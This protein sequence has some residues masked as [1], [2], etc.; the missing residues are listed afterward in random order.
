MFEALLLTA[1]LAADLDP[2]AMLKTADA[3]RQAFL[4]SSLRLRATIE[5]ADKP[6]Q[7]GEFDIHIGNDDQQ[8]VVFRDK[9][10][11][12][13]KFLIVGDRAWLLVPGARNPVA[14]TPNQRMM[15]AMAFTDIARVRLSSDYIGTLRPGMEPCGEPAQP[16]RVMDI[17]ATIKTAPYAS[18]ALW[19]DGDGLLRKAVYALASGKP[20]KEISYRYRDNLGQLEPSGMTLVDLLMPGSNAT[21]ML[22]IVSRRSV[23]HP[24]AMF[25]PQEQVKR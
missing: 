23:Q 21:T 16:C 1:A 13:R 10:Q 3:P 24:A 9:R 11:K 6:S 20:A 18:G 15:G 4:H 2:A 7:T 19:I 14:V 5:Q 25:D 8:L 17:T 12:G 22:E